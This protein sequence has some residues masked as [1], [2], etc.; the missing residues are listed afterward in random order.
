MTSSEKN[1]NQ[2][3]LTLSRG[4]LYARLELS[5]EESLERDTRGWAARGKINGSG[6]YAS[7]AVADIAQEMRFPHR[8]PARIIR[9]ALEGG[10]TI[11]WARE[12]GALLIEY[13]ERKARTLGI[14]DDQPNKAA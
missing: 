10:A 1:G 14:A 8:V 13:A 3:A 2:Q 9:E 12:F 11:G 6:A 7:R 4:G 5:P